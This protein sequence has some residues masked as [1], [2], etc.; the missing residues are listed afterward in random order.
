[1]SSQLYALYFQ[2]HIA[3]RRAQILQQEKEDLVNAY[4]QVWIQK[5]FWYYGTRAI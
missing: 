2:A 3:E 5:G 1:M 4:E